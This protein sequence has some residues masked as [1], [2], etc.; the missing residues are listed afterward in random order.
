L[1][2]SRPEAANRALTF[3]YG[4]GLDTPQPVS[5]PA[6]AV[7]YSSFS[8]SFIEFSPS[9]PFSNDDGGSVVRQQSIAQ[10]GNSSPSLNSSS[11]HTLRCLS[12]SSSQAAFANSCRP[13]SSPQLGYLCRLCPGLVRQSVDLHI[14]HIQARH[15]P[16]NLDPSRPYQCYC[17]SRAQFK[18]RREFKRHLETTSEHRETISGSLS[19]TYRCRCGQP[20]TRKDK[21]LEHV[22]GNCTGGLPY[23]CVCGPVEGDITEHLK[24]GNKKS[25]RTRKMK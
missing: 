8:S 12:S 7:P 9:P 4:N 25:G 5:S 21:F 11:P 14:N 19:P 24:S 10:A 2:D 6:P 15:R 17:R 23:Q 18:R 22:R 20:F 16:E 13:N 3:S 1:S